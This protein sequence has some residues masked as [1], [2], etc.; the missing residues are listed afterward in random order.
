MILASTDLRDIILNNPAKDIIAKHR[1]YSKVM[2]M[3]LYGAGLTE[4]LEKIEHFEDPELHKARV[5]YTRSNKALFASLGRPID[6]VYSAKGGSVNYNLSESQN[7]TASALAGKIRDGISIKK[8]L[9]KSWTAHLK[10][11]PGGIIFIEL[12]TGN[13]M[14]NRFT[15]PF[16]YPTYKA[17]SA[18]WDYRSTGSYLEYVVF[19]MTES[20]IKA[21]GITEKGDYFRVVDDAFDMIVR[22]KGDEVDVLPGKTIPNYFSYV[23]AMLNSD[24]IDPTN[25]DIRL[26]IFD[27]V[28]DLA[29]E[30]LI[31]GSIKV[32]HDFMHGFPKYWEHVDD[33]ADCGGTGMIKGEKHSECKGTGKRIMM[34]VSDVKL[35]AYP[36]KE[37]PTVAPNVAGYVEPSKIYY[38][39]ATADL[40]A[41]QDAMQ[42]TMWGNHAQ[43]QVQASGKQDATKTATEIVTDQQPMI[44]RLTEISESAEKRHKFILDSLIKVQLA[45]GYAGSSVSY[46]RRY[47][48]E[49]P[50]VL[51]EKYNTARK[52]GVSVSLLSDMWQQYIESE[53][54]SDPIGLEIA[55]K[56]KGVE[57]AIHYTLDQVKMNG[58]P[59]EDLKAKMFYSDWLEQMN[60]NMLL[61]LSAETLKGLLYAY[62]GSK[63]LPQPE[64]A[65]V[66]V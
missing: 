46:G 54:V 65:K 30:Y 64:P 6:K 14:D 35:L 37:N 22:R 43:P 13:T 21:A 47:H 56:L 55:T 39:I 50:D 31:K 1:M 59:E 33:C 42:F 53:Y 4:S 23:P 44:D 29:R 61:L 17:S 3:H 58:F 26:S 34:K 40:N 25:D 2:Q 57:P 20:Q 49:G 51:L 66:P 60:D 16:C 19:E 18:I 28:M 63:V 36:D 48:I 41:L 62:S 12:G 9:D 45:P 15:K 27:E 32:T 38:E 52:N 10:D 7:K 11:D 5:K 8:W 24:I